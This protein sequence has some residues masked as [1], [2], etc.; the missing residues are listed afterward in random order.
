MGYFKLPISFRKPYLGW[1][2]GNPYLD[3]STG[4]M[5]VHLYCSYKNSELNLQYSKFL[6]ELKLGRKLIPFRE[7]VHHKDKNPL[8]NK[9][10]NLQIVCRKIHKSKLHSKIRIITVR[11]ENCGKKFK[12]T[13][14]Q[15]TNRNSDYRRRGRIGALVCSN[16]CRASIGVNLRWN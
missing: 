10:A 8:N 4:R 9:I 7:D 15:Q 2:I 1:R 5:R 12:L 6:M 16:F 14:K 11:C 3:T 13:P